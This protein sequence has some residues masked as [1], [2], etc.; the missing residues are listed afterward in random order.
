MAKY[1]AAKFKVHVDT[2]DKFVFEDKGIPVVIR[3]E[4]T[5][6]RTLRGL[7]TIT[8]IE[9]FDCY[10]C[11]KTFINSKVVMK[12][13]LRIIGQET[14]KLNLRQILNFEGK[15]ENIVKVNVEI[16][17]DITGLVASTNKIIFGN[18][19]KYKISLN[20]QQATPVRRGHSCPINVSSLF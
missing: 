20:L 14:I 18:K 12:Q 8:V 16:V 10:A 13:S 9:D 2:V 3:T 6:G 1:V 15:N 11:C 4:C 17:E 19:D 5:D 7:A